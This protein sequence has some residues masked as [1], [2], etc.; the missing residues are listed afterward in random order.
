MPGRLILIIALIRACPKS[1]TSVQLECDATEQPDSA[2]EI[3]TGR[4]I[5]RSATSLI[6][7]LNRR[8]DSCSVVALSITF[9]TEIS[10]VEHSSSPFDGHECQK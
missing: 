2:G 7:G 3:I 1:R 6:A 9:G 5:H 10:N 8:L 4:E